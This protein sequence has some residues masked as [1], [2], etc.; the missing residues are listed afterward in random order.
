[1]TLVQE[2]VSLLYQVCSGAFRQNG[3][4][5]YLNQV[6]FGEDSDVL[7]KNTIPPDLP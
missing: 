3:T 6:V 4:V 2:N 7:G 5:T 1:M